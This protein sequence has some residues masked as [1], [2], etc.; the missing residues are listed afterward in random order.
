MEILEL[1]TKVSDRFFRAF[2]PKPEAMYDLETLYNNYNDLFFD[3]ELP[4]L[5]KVVKKVKGQEVVS[6]SRLKWDGR[7]RSRTYGTYT[8]SSR[9]GY[10]VIR[11][12]RN[13]AGSPVQMKSTLVHEMLHQWLDLNGQD[14]G[15]SGHGKNFILHAKRINESCEGMGWKTRV[16]FF[17]KAIFS[18]TP[19]FECGL[20]G[21]TIY[22]VKDLDIARTA[23]HIIH[24]AFDGNHQTIY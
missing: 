7:L 15:V 3:G 16:N 6:F 19:H 20:I 23:E 24:S 17:D 5:V 12:A 21:K 2:G 18:E 22:S 8:A 14:D 10:G 11:L 13:I 4:E 1:P 9:R